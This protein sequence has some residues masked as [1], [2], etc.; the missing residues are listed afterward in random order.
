MGRALA[1]IREAAGDALLVGEVYLPSDRAGR[2][3]SST[4]TL[5]FSFEFLHAPRDAERLAGVIAA[6]L[7][8]GGSALAALQPR[9][10]PPG[11]AGS[12][13]RY[14]RAWRP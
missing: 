7:A 4:S 13:R 11:R 2:R 9:L 1:A 14:A 6:G 8:A 12:A 5:A 10:P 3:T